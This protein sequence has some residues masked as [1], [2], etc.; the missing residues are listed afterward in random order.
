MAVEDQRAKFTIP[1]RWY[2]SQLARLVAV[3]YGHIGD[4]FA[5]TKAGGWWDIVGGRWGV[6][7]GLVV[8]AECGGP[9]R[10]S[11]SVSNACRSRQ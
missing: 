8:D 10:Q 6:M 5:S 1:S 2:D 4:P 7:S 3:A 9:G 11:V